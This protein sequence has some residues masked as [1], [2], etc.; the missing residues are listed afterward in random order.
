[1]LRSLN[2]NDPAPTL[3]SYE[4]AIFAVLKLQVYKTAISIRQ[5]EGRER[6]QIKQML[7]ARTE[8]QPLARDTG[9]PT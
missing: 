9:T 1:M 4:H 6:N 2:S 3:F 7:E 5:E 8:W